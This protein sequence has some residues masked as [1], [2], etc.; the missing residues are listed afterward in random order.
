MNLAQAKQIAGLAGNVFEGTAD[1]TVATTTATSLFGAGTGSRTFAAN[2]LKAGKAIQVR[3]VGNLTTPALNT[4]TIAIA[5]KLTNGGGTA[6]T[7]ATG[8]T[9]ALGASLVAARFELLIDITV[10]TVG[11]TG[12]LTCL[13]IL[14]TYAATS[15]STDSS[16][17][18]DANATFDTTQTETLDVMWTWSAVT[19]QTATARIASIDT[20]N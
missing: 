18:F 4:A 10:R 17:T 11:P 19:T 5:P 2:A 6:V 9:A 20:R 15:S 14:T 12:T 7:L 1:V 3:I 16:T 8:T 13:G